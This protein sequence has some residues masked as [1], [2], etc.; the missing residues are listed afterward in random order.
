MPHFEKKTTL[1]CTALELYAWHM[2]PNAFETL[3][4]PAEKVT[5]VSRPEIFGE[6]AEIELRICV[7]PMRISWIA[8]HE[9]FIEGRRFDDIQRSG[10]FKKWHHSHLFEP[11][12]ESTCIMHDLIHFEIPG[13]SL[14][15]RLFSPMVKLRLEKMFNYRHQ[16]LVSIFGK[17]D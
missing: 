6:G 5:V 10:P 12:T 7:G 9:N 16:Q 15:N 8:L 17:I 11:Q 3:T 2:Q 1:S 4:P 13:G 14:I